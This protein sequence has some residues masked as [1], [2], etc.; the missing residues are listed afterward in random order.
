MICKQAELAER[1]QY[2]AYP[3]KSLVDL[4]YEN[5][6]TLDAVAAGQAPLLGDFMEAIYEARIRRNPDRIQVQLTREGT[7]AGATVRIT[8]GLTLDAGSP[9]L[10]IAYLLENLPRDRQLHFAVELNF[11]GLPD[12]A[13]DRFFRDIEGHRLGQFGARLDLADALG[14]GLVDEW[15]GIDAGLRVSRPTN[16]WTFP[17][18]TVSG[19]EGGFE[20]IHQSTVVQPHWHVTP[21]AEGRWSVTMELLL[22]TSRAEQ[23]MGQVAAAVTG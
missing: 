1:I 9:T 13:D 21:D 8:K 7:A 17:V 6:A 18:A 12:A 3:R 22:D 10:V 20:S 19:S 2:D 11:A 5:D 4:F 14:L 16:F 23:R 15:L